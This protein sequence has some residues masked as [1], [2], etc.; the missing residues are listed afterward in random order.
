MIDR[1]RTLARL[2]K[3][4]ILSYWGRCGIAVRKHKFIDVN[5]GTAELVSARTAW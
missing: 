5:S 2:G 1:A 3:K 4:S